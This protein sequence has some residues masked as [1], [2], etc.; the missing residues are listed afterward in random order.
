MYIPR[1]GKKKRKY[2]PG[3]KDE[4]IFSISL[5]FIDWL[6]PSM[7]VHTSRYRKIQKTYSAP[8][9]ISS[10]PPNL[11]ST[12]W[13]FGLFWG[14]G[15]PINQSGDMFP[16][17]TR[18][19][20]YSHKFRRE[21]EGGTYRAAKASRIASPCVHVEATTSWRNAAQK[22]WVI[23]DPIYSARRSPVFPWRWIDDGWP[24]DHHL[25][26][27][28]ESERPS[29]VRQWSAHKR[30]QSIFFP[31]IFESRH[32]SP[33]ESLSP[34]IQSNGR[35]RWWG[36]S[37]SF[38]III[39]LFYF[40]YFHGLAWKILARGRIAFEKRDNDT[41]REKEQGG[42]EDNGDQS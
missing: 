15:W 11:F 16:K 39:I 14:S 17:G 21:I 29:L 41:R 36:L 31:F 42:E 10:R 23:Y 28:Q 38:S 3:R 35:P 30:R 12:V 9:H 27:A 37:L 25:P 34:L 26:S 19:H 6:L 8:R 4:T 18:E 2:Q 33:S 40:L 1:L 32:Q 5:L 20:G 22:R 13:F 7:Y 24:S